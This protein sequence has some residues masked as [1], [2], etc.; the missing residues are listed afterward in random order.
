MILY[1]QVLKIKSK[2]LNIKIMPEDVGS[3]RAMNYHYHQ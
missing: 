3:L 1:V 2:C